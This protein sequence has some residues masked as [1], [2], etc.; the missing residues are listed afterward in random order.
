MAATGQVW[1]PRAGLDC[2]HAL[3]ALN[4]V[5]AALSNPADPDAAYLPH[6]LATLNAVTL[7]NPDVEHYVSCGPLHPY[8]ARAFLYAESIGSSVALLLHLCRLTD[9]VGLATTPHAP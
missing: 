8:L 3:M 2:L 5:A 4:A 1:L 9:W 7:P 6:T